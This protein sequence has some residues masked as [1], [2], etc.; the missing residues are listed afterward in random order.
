MTKYFVLYTAGTP[1]EHEA[2][3]LVASF[4]AQQVFVCGVPYPNSKNWMKNCMMRAPI[5][6]GIADS[7]P[8]DTICMFDADVRC[9]KYPALLE[10]LDGDMGCEDHGIQH[11]AHGQHSAGVTIWAPTPAGRA[12]LKSWAKLC[13]ED[14]TPGAYL[15]EQVYLHEAIV[16]AQKDPAFRYVNIGNKYNRQEEYIVPGDDTVL[17]HHTASRK[18]LRKIGGRR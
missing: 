12:V 13:A 16:E 11:G 17:A 1:Y 4:A 3:L 14:P 6:S 8:N 10:N 5:L 7:N 2:L 18:Y 9:I 15:R